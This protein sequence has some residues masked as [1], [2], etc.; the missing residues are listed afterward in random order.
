MKVN[1]TILSTFLK[2]A[3]V[4]KLMWADQSAPLQ[5]HANPKVDTL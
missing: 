2:M 5:C 3:V 1:T 4:L